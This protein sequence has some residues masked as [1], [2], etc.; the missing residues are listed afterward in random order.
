[1][2]CELRACKGSLEALMRSVQMEVMERKEQMAQMEQAW[3]AAVDEEAVVRRATAVH[4]ETRISDL[5]AGSTGMRPP[6]R[7]PEGATPTEGGLREAPEALLSPAA[8]MTT[9]PESAEEE[10]LARLDAGLETESRLR[11][12]LQA[13]I[14]GRI[15]CLAKRLEEIAEC[16][17]ASP[18]R[19]GG[20][21]SR[22]LTGGIADW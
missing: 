21:D 15:D 13:S 3:R 1:M 4:L 20:V 8:A 6:P 10:L 19:G 22:L 11:G 2:R 9:L 18:D 14:V 7:S 17:L 16:V 5:L 12:E